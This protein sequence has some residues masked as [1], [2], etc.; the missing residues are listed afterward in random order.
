MQGSIRMAVGFLVVFGA[1]GSLDFDSE[2]SVLVQ[3]AIAVVGLV[4]AY[5][6]VQA[7]KAAQ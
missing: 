2:A 1:V 7:M 5:S 4:V 6:G 3:T